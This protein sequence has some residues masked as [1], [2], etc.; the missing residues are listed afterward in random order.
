MVDA[1]DALLG[2]TEWSVALSSCADLRS[3]EWLLDD[4]TLVEPDG[5]EAL[6]DLGNMLGGIAM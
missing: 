3:P 5:G 1:E 4:D 6:G 2:N